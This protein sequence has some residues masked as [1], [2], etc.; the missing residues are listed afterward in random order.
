MIVFLLSYVPN[1]RMNKR[2]ELA[3]K[4]SPTAV[5]CAKR[6]VGNLWEPFHHDVPHH[7]IEC[8]MP[9]LKHPVKRMLSYFSFKRFVMRTLEKLQ[10]TCLYLQGLDC[11]DIAYHYRKKH[12]SVKIVFEV[13]DVREPFLEEKKSIITRLI[14]RK[15]R[16]LFPAV[17]HLVIT[18]DKFYDVHYVDLISRDK[19]IVAPNIPDLTFFK[20]FAKEPHERF[21]VGFIGGLRYMTQLKLLV[22]ASQAADV[23]V[24]FAGGGASAGFDAELQSYCQGKANIRLLGK[25]KYDTSIAGLYKNIDCVYSVYDADNPNV[26][27]ALPNKLYEAV[28]CELPLLAA[29]NTYLGEIVSKH[30]IGLCVGHRKLDELT[31]ALVQM[32]TD[33]KLY[34]QLVANCRLAQASVLSSAYNQELEEMI[35]SVLR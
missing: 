18:S 26:R 35:A 14:L 4:I 1:P 20:G 16:K 27:I 31:Q 33:Q 29:S 21:T 3:K 5:V 22:D 28:Y 2:I 6:R 25:Y 13:A 10:P 17:S 15:E 11:L 30:S 9:Q 34:G 8:D 7:I 23:D 19:V 32:K 24:V 12:P